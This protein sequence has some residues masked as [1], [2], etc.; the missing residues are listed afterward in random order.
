M[1]DQWVNESD[2]QTEE[3]AGADEYL[4]A[5]CVC[6]LCVRMRIHA[7]LETQLRAHTH[8]HTHTGTHGPTITHI[9]ACGTR[10]G[11]GGAE[12]GSSWPGS[13]STEP[14]GD[15][16]RGE[17]SV[18]ARSLYR[19]RDDREK[20]VWYAEIIS[21]HSSRLKR[22]HAHDVHDRFPRLRDERKMFDLPRLSPKHSSQ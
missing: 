12:R 16:K 11:P 19:L 7:R 13:S 18:S 6:V 14:V 5:R 8:K 21:K 17:V 10:G 15:E 2:S 4:R 20:D 1:S 9:P 22:L 3:R